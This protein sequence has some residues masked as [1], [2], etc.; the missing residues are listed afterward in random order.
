[1][2]N[3]KEFLVV[4]FVN[5]YGANDSVNIPTLTFKLPSFHIPPTFCN[6][7]LSFFL[8]RNLSFTSSFGT[9]C[10]CTT[11]SDQPQ[12]SCLSLILYNVYMNFTVNHLSSLGYKCLISADDIVVISLNKLLDL[13]IASLNQTLIEFHNIFNDLSFSVSYDKCKSVIFT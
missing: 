4:T 5:I 9:Q 11:F 6:F 13:V 2:F 3:D 8:H 1:M 12:G 7:I 10:S